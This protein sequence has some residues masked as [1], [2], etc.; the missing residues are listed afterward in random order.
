MICNYRKLFKENNP[1]RLRQEQDPRTKE[2]KYECN[3]YLGGIEGNKIYYGKP[4]IYD[5]D[6]RV[7]FYVSE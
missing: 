2:Y 1:I 7:H 3:L 5:S 4:V 6:D